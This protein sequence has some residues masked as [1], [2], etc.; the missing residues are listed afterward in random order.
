MNKHDFEHLK[1]DV[2]LWSFN[3]RRSRHIRRREVKTEDGF[4]FA[5]GSAKYLPEI[6]KLHLQLFRKGLLG[7]LRWVY[8]FRAPE[9]ISVLLNDKGELVGYDMFMFN[10]A[11]DGLNIIHELYV[12][13]APAYQGQGLAVKLRRYSKDCYDHGVLSA[14]STLAGVYDIKALRTAQKA[15]FF[16]TKRSA[17]PPAHY[18]ICNLTKRQ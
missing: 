15:G 12:G 14:I 3:M 6:E 2:S 7:W 18:L 10:T 4:T 5:P 1:H 17:K 16:I 13:I 9:L 11:E 8:K